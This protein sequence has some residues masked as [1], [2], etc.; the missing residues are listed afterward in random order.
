[1]RASG[2]ERQEGLRP[3]VFLDRDGTIILDRHYLGSA[4]G[5]ELIPGAGQAIARL[6]RAG[7][8]V[9]L[10]TNQSGIGRGYLPGCASPCCRAA[11]PASSTA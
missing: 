11:A 10:V 8:P 4:D 9:V 3:G 7:V 6:N 1:M 2:A 5:V